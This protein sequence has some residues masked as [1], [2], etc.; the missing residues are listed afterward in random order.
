MVNAVKCLKCGSIII[1]RHTHDFV[2]CACQNI[3]MDGGSSYKRRGGPGLDDGT[4]EE[5]DEIPLF[6][7]DD[8]RHLEG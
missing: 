8:G 3:F 1:S 7:E 2:W 4:Y 5:L 6:V